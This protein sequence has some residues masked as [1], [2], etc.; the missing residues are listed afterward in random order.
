MGDTLTANLDP[1]V[2]SAGEAVE[3]AKL[4]TEVSLK[5]V[6]PY[7]EVLR[8]ELERVSMAMVVRSRQACERG[9]T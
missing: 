9:R 6:C 4:G 5:T 2:W 7:R 8:G 3:T 1:A